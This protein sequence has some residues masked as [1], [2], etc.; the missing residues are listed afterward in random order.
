VLDWARWR[1]DWWLLLAGLL[2]ATVYYV[3]VYGQALAWFPFLAG[4]GMAALRPAGTSLRRR[5]LL[6][7]CGRELAEARRLLGR[8]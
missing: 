5:L 7:Q 6:R 3:V 2:T 4:V 8:E 1:G